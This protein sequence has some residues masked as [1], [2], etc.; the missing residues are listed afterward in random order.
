M[1]IVKQAKIGDYT[2]EVA[3]GYFAVFDRRNPE[4]DPILTLDITDATD[5]INWLY[6]QVQAVTPQ[7]HGQDKQPV[8]VRKAEEGP[9]P[10]EAFEGRSA[11]GIQA[12]KRYFGETISMPPTA[13]A[14]GQK[15]FQEEVIDLGAQ[16]KASGV[17]IL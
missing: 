11:G 16:A 2:F 3:S 14:T 4:E 1:D 15:V 12:A 17:A 7:R 6:N 8:M 10:Q 13:N 9:K 5:L